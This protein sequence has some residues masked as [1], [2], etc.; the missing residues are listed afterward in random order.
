MQNCDTVLP[1]MSLRIFQVDAFTGTRFTGNPATVVL[2]AEAQAEPTLRAIAREFAHAETA[3]VFPAAAADHDLR[4]RFFNARQESPFVGHATIAAHAVLAALGRRKPGVCRQLSGTGILEVRCGDPDAT[5]EFRQSVP[6]L[7]APLP[8]KAT[9]RVAEA[10][11]LQGTQLHEA[12]P[13]RIARKG[14]SRLLVP[15]RDALALDGLAPHFDGLIDLGNELKA[16]GFFVFAV[17]SG[18]GGVATDSRMFCPA[19]GIPEDPVSGNAHAMLAAYLWSLGWPAG[20]APAFIGRQGRQMGRPGEV[21]VTLDLGEQGLSAVRIA[22]R[23]V[24]VS[25]GYLAD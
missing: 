17:G 2:D 23:A 5:V 3:F 16:D 10:L 15:V 12:M 7:D 24:I 4:L 21:G 25:E 6:E 20:D 11:R 19:L 8:L 18:P 13:A 1:E 14:S 9:L 22:G